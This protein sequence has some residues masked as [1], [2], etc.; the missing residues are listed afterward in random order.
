MVLADPTND[1]A[2]LSNIASPAANYLGGLA[3]SVTPPRGCT[4]DPAH[5]HLD[6][7]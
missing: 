2:V 6:Y 1:L 5:M 4:N 7:Y 3:A